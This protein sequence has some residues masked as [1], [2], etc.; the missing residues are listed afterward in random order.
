MTP[1]TE[2]NVSPAGNAGKTEYE[3][4]APPLLVGLLAV[5]AV[6]LVY[7]AGL[8]E[9]LSAEGAISLTVMLTEAVVEPPVFV[10]VT[11]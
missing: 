9:Y 6:S 11:V 7:V 10:A 3:T 5:I 1:L 2:F 4:T 8:L